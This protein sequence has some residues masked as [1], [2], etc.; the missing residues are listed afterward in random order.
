MYIVI[1]ED[2]VSDVR[3]LKH[4]LQQH[5]IVCQAQVIADGHEAILFAG[6]IAAGAAVPDL[7]V[8]DLNL[9]KRDGMEVLRAIRH[10]TWLA[11]VQVVVLTTSESPTDRARAEQLGV[12]AYLTKPV[13]LDQFTALGAEFRAILYPGQAAAGRAAAPPQA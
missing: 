1:I 10:S 8:L 6:S 5:G 3:L 7:I 13:A 9:P 2:N 4:A 11:H 12:R